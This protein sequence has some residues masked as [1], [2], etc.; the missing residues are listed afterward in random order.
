MKNIIIGTAGHVDHGKTCLIKA[1][2]GIETDRLEEEKKRGITIELGFAYLDLPNGEKAGII[3]VPGHER[4]IKNML[5]GAGGMDMVL[6]VVAADEG[7]MPQTR[8]H[9][10]ILS[11]LGIENGI[12]VLT[13]SDI[14]EE[15]WLEFVMGDVKSELESTFLSK[16]KIMPVSSY[17]GDGIEELKKE[18]VSV[19]EKTKPKS[20]NKSFRMPV[21]RVF[22]KKGFGTVVTGTLI[23]GALNMGDNISIYPS[24]GITKIR[25]I[26]VHGQA[27]DNAYAGQRVAINL[28]K[29][30]KDEVMRGDTLAQPDSMEQTMML[31]VKLNLFSDTSRIVENGST[32]HFYHGTRNVL[33]KVVLLDR[34]SL[35]A[36]ESCYAQ[37]R[38][39]ENIAVKNGDHYIVRFYSPIETIGGGEILDANP[40]KHKRNNQGI[41]DSLKIKETGTMTEKVLQA[42]KEYSPRFESLVYISK[43]LMIEANEL[44]EELSKI[45][46]SELVEVTDR[47]VVHAGFIE[48]LRSRM[49]EFLKEHHDKNPLEA[50]MK[51]D[52]L[53]YRLMPKIDVKTADAVIDVF[54]M[55]NVIKLVNQKAALYDFEISIDDNQTKLMDEISD[56]YLE[57]G[58]SV[59]DVDKV[60][61]NYKNNR[62]AFKQVV[63]YMV[64]IKTLINITGQ[65]YLHKDNFLKALD[66]MENIQSEKGEISLGDFR[67]RVGTSRKFAL[68]ILE[69]CDKMKVTKRAGDQRKLESGGLQSIKKVL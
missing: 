40:V 67:D 55:Q 31:D 10:G 49:S 48:R 14:V 62:A 19:L 52:E 9:L 53:K 28:N 13:K 45:E 11:M 26:Q 42:V 57:A 56:I 15:D 37:L 34:D 41:I 1:L 24:E 65:I 30:K 68:P 23:E 29:L 46:P 22:S 51:L 63:E 18:I 60:Q 5:A 54:A 17:T 50:G 32:V 35:K 38:F 61:E 25:N 69:Y 59:P 47:I 6:L 12:V 66:E 39:N 20:I 16:A 27:V 44:K 3:D 4:F 43:R 58:F 21:D 36:G 2:T 33:C 7:I 8:E 64:D